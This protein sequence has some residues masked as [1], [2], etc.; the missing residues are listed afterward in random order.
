MSIQESKEIIEFKNKIIELKNFVEYIDS[1]TNEHSLY[2][3]ITSGVLSKKTFEDKISELSKCVREIN[4]FLNSS[5]LQNLF[6]IELVKLNLEFSGIT[7][8]LDFLSQHNILTGSVGPRY[9]NFPDYC[10][11]NCGDYIDNEKEFWKH[12]N[13]CPMTNVICDKCGVVYKRKHY[14][15]HLRKMG[16]Q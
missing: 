6:N 1:I 9:N 2:F 14:I 10:I 3:Q 5:T 15:R 16:H 13:K 8:D 11:E 7:S 12:T 4:I